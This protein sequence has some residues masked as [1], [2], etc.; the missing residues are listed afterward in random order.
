[1]SD[2]A[3]AAAE[4]RP[5]AQPTPSPDTEVAAP[6]LRT[7]D[8]V[9][10][11]G[12]GFLGSG[13]GRARA[14]DGVSFTVPAGRVVGLLGP[15]GA[16]K[17]TLLKCLVGL[18]APTSGQAELLGH[19]A[20]HA[21]SRARVGALVGRPALV[22]YLTGRRNLELRA[23]FY[24]GAAAR[25]DEVLYRVGMDEAAGRKVN[26]YSTGMRQRLGLA[27]SL[28]NEPALWILDEPT[29]GLDPRGQAEV[30]RLIR[31]AG[32]AQDRTVL[33]S[34]HN[35]H[36]IEQ[37][38][39]HVVLLSKGKVL[40]SGPVGE[41]LGREQEAVE[42]ECDNP[43]RARRLIDALT[44]CRRVEDGTDATGRPVL[45]ATG[46]PSLAGDVAR[47]LV[48]AGITLGALTP[49]RRNLED[50]FLETVKDEAVS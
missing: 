38:C 33:V 1:M 50:F 25:V 2:A 8:L 18:L 28:L 14:L 17:T 27:A 13:G 43:E 16:G 3:P 39:D 47:S 48:G 35:L 9:K 10:R 5:A 23:R 36:E 37:L 40:A 31:E 22:P 29:S 19:H 21:A 20:G 24:P 34:S 42:V 11:Y 15:N 44:S 30:R 6:A 26:A 49:R 4:P 12:W 7:V 46:D 41:L 45:V 32:A